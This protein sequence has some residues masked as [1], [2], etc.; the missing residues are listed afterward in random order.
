MPYWSNRFQD[1]EILAVVFINDTYYSEFRV[2]QNGVTRILRDIRNG[3][4]SLIPTIV[5]EMKDGR[6]FV[7][8]ASAVVV[9]QRP[10]AEE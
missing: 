4:M 3:E 7:M 6:Q 1:G 9:E 5:V 8:D 10:G 2:G